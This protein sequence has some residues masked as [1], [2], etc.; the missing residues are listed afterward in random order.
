MNIQI[1]P[2]VADELEAFRR[3]LGYSFHHDADDK[4]ADHFAKILELDRSFAAFDD[5]ELVG[6]GG[7]FSFGI[8][9]PGGGSVPAGG[10]TMI[11]VRGTHRRRGVLSSM[12]RYHLDEVRDRGDAVAAL[13]AS[14]S[15]IYGRYGFG[16]AAWRHSVTIDRPHVRFRDDAP[17]RSGRIDL[18]EPADHLPDLMRVYD[19]AR[20]VRSG[21]LSRSDHWW[22]EIRFYD[23]E[24]WR[25]GFTSFRYALYRE[26][27]EARGYARYRVKENWEEGFPAGKLGIGEVLAMD[28]EAYAGIWRFLIGIDL[29]GEITTWNSPVDDPLP[30]LL[31]DS[32][33]VRRKLGDSLWVK[34]VDIP[35]AL[36]ERRYAVPGH[37]VFEVEDPFNEEINGVYELDGGPDGAECTPSEREPEFSIDNGDLGAIYLGGNRLDTL[38]RAGRVTGHPA[39]LHRADLMFSWT[40]APWCPEVF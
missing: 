15:S 24:D 10:T 4:H 7:A 32:R 1:R 30:W 8:S 12:M 35:A 40:P 34:P 9:V 39:A 3:Q 11:T 25:D 2:V 16:P 22:R 28:L 14:E 27:G 20:T 37:V 33:R 38:V 21:M 18:I 23:P 5:D 29:I 17:G 6:T 19:D 36:S 13:W 31:E 26:N